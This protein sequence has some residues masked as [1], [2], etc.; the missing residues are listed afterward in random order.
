[1]KFNA[2]E[3]GKRIFIICLASL[4][5]AVNIKSFVRTGGLYPGGATGLTI[6]IQRVAQLFLNVEL[7]Y[8]VVNLLLNAVPVYIGF[9]F[10]GKKFTLYSC[11]MIV[12]TSVLTDIVPGYTI[13]Y[14]TL[15]ISIFG[16]MINGLVI[17]VCLLVN[18]TT[19]GTDFIAIFLSEKKGVDSFNIIL[20]LNVVIL[21]AAGILFGWDKA[22]YSIIFQYASTQ[23]LHTLYKKYQ[24]NTLFVVTNKPQEVSEAIARECNHGATI[25]EGEGSYEHCERHVVYS[26]VSSAESKRVIH[27][28]KET[29]PEA[30]VNVIRTEQL[31]GRFYQKPTE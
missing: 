25:L 23:V 13:T 14:D 12:L 18:A 26:V 20:A 9:R 3:D 16:G 10:I 2:K 31:S 17:S 28:V 30:F 8:S 4:L 24:Q 11:L 22:L 15:L 21:A 5:M 19:G 1:M 6:L 7:P 29:D 27:A